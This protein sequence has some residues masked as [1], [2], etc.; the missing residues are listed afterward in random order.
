MA[1]VNA[2]YRSKKAQEKA[3]SALRDA[4]ERCASPPESTTP[5]FPSTTQI[6]PPQTLIPPASVLLNQRADFDTFPRNF[7]VPLPGLHAFKEKAEFSAESELIT[8]VM[9]LRA[10]LRASKEKL[11]Y[12]Q[13][14][15]K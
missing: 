15:G 13:N 11:Q 5:H 4:R 2:K 9:K 7:H 6:S 3:A 8:E 14:G 10:E 12:Y 1:H